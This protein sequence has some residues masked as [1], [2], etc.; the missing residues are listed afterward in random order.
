M[1]CRVPANRGKGITPSGVS[2]TFWNRLISHGLGW[3]ASRLIRCLCS[4]RGRLPPPLSFIEA[5]PICIPF[6]SRP[7]GGYTRA[8]PG[9]RFPPGGT[10]AERV[11][12]APLPRTA[13]SPP[14][15]SATSKHLM[16]SCGATAVWEVTLV[17]FLPSLMF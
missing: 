3:G 10:G 6:P 9:N 1:R 14:P 17:A 2:V 16:K 15:F 13:P 8:L 12:E 5:G 7:G 11:R 4:F